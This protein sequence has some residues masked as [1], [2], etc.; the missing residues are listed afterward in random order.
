MR[1][2]FAEELEVQL[3]TMISYTSQRMPLGISARPTTLLLQGLVDTMT[4]AFELGAGPIQPQDVSGRRFLGIP[5]GYSELSTDSR[6][7]CAA[8]L[9]I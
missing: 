5:T 4:D 2:P 8:T 1:K 6:H 9:Q 7:G 3:R